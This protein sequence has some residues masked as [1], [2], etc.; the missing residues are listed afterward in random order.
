VS[1]ATTAKTARSSTVLRIEAVRLETVDADH[2]IGIDVMV[3]SAA[4]NDA[5]EP[6]GGWAPIRHAGRSMSAGRC[7]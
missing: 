5:N 7:P 3:G 1:A 2:R 6:P 4:Q